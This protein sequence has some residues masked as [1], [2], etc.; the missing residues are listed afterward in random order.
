VSH[1][2]MYTRQDFIGEQRELLPA[3]RTRINARV[4]EIHPEVYPLQ[5]AYSGQTK[6][7]NPTFTKRGIKVSVTNSDAYQAELDQRAKGA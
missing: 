5:A 1:T 7:S 2:Q 3:N 4:V 6:D